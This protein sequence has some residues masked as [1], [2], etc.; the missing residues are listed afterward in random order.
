MGLEMA[1]LSR[2]NQRKQHFIT[3]G[4]TFLRDERL[5]LKA[6]GLL[7][8]MLSYSDEIDIS[9]NKLSEKSTG[10][11]RATRSAFNEL[12]TLGYVYRFRGTEKG[13]YVYKY[14][15]DEQPI[16]ISKAERF[17]IRGNV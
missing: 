5:S 1:N 12:H 4:T 6:K 16:D 15:Y 3:V 7:A 17:I 9:L 8:L 14:L 11:I 2:F 13:K 10:E